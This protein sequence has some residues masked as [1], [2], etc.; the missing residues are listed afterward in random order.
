MSSMI[1]FIN[2]LWVSL[3]FCGFLGVIGLVLGQALLPLEPIP[4]YLF[5]LKGSSASI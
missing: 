4:N 2:D 1:I 5:W 3:F